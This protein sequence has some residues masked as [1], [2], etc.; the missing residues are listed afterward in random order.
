[1]KNMSKS[2]EVLTKLMELGE[3]FTTD[4]AKRR[5]GLKESALYYHLRRLVEIGFLERIGKGKYLIKSNPNVSISPDAFLLASLLVKPGAIAYW[6][7]LNYYGLTEQIPS[8]IFIQTPRRTGI[9]K[10]PNIKI[11]S[12]KPHK[13]FGLNEV[14]ISEKIIKITDPEKTIID[15]LDKPKYCGGLI[16]VAKALKNGSFDFDKMLNYVKK[17]ENVAI[18]K[19][20]GFL[21]EKLGLGIEVKIERRYLRSYPLLDPTMPKVGEINPRWGLIIN[22]PKNYLEELE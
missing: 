15:C 1:M 20:L 5:L 10:F 22:I 3:V 13:F 16:E 21:C 9:S 12:V 7:A 6:S 17:M 2:I 18:L 8:T 19:R 14:K 11:V 4:E